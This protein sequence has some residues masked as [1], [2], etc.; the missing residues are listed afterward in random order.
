MRRLEDL[1]IV[2]RNLRREGVVE[3]LEGKLMLRVSKQIG[4]CS[5]K[6]LKESIESME[7]F[8]MVTSIHKK[9][10][11]YRVNSVVEGI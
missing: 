9:P 6:L 11:V 1:I 10:S 5:P 3:I 4:G 8:E 2:W 7:M